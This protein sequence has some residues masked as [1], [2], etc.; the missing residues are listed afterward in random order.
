[1]VI[2]LDE[3]DVIIPMDGILI[4]ADDCDYAV[5]YYLEMEDGST[6]D[7]SRFSLGAV[8][9]AITIFDTGIVGDSFK[10]V[11]YV[12][13]HDLKLGVDIFAADI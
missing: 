3:G 1:M 5:N 4:E 13:E 9:G 8:T 12:M 11:F 2:Y 10:L 7:P 6:L